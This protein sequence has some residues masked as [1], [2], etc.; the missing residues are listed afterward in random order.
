ML[1][2]IAERDHMVLSSVS[3]E[4]VSQ[5]AVVGCGHTDRFELIFGTSIESRKAQNILN[6]ARV[7]AVIGLDIN[8]TIQYE[9]EARKLEGD[10]RETYTELYFAKIPPARKNK[11]KPGQTYFLVTPKWIRHTDIRTSPWTVTEL[12]F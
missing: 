12:S 7:S 9:G 1:K 8:G 2:F 6:N 11:D 4:G 10:E 5:S 3:Q